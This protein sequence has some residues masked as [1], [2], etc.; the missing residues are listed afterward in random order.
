VILLY[1]VNDSTA[2]TI[3]L[4]LILPAVVFLLAWQRFYAKEVGGIF[5]RNDHLSIDGAFSSMT[6]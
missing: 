3:V 2:I 6:R 1:H 5:I 4:Y